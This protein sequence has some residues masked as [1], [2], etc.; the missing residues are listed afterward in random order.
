M[1]RP[2]CDPQKESEYH[3]GRARP[4]SISWKNYFFHPEALIG[5]RQQFCAESKWVLLWPIRSWL[6][7]T[8]FYSLTLV[9]NPEP[10]RWDQAQ[11]ASS[12]KF[13]F[14]GYLNKAHSLY[15][16][17]LLDETSNHNHFSYNLP[18]VK[19]QQMAVKQR[20]ETTLPAFVTLLFGFYYRKT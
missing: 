5:Y 19:K 14:H 6:I 7:T 16:R 1:C 15:S 17:W 9:L 10:F 3:R 4:L 18:S 20:R 2:V 11:F 13:S 8:F 12:E